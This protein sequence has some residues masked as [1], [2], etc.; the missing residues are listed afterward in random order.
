MIDWRR[1]SAGFPCF[2]RDLA[3]PTPDRRSKDFHF[4]HHLHHLEPGERT[5]GIEVMAARVVDAVDQLSHVCRKVILGRQLGRRRDRR[6]SVNGSESLKGNIIMFTDAEINLHTVRVKNEYFKRSANKP[7]TT[8][9]GIWKKRLG[10][11]RFLRYNRK[12]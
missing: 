9:N 11:N 2:A 3:F 6:L 1:Q 10:R 12:H 8:F 4:L 5:P 7:L